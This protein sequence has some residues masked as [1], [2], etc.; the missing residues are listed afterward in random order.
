MEEHSTHQQSPVMVPRT[1]T[2]PSLREATTEDELVAPQDQRLSSLRYSLDDDTRHCSEEEDDE[3][4]DHLSSL[5]RPPLSA[6]QGSGSPIMDQPNIPTNVLS[7]VTSARAAIRALTARTSQT[8][9]HMSRDCFHHRA[10]Q[11]ALERGL[12]ALCFNRSRA[13][14]S[15]TTPGAI[16]HSR[17]AE[18]RTARQRALES[19]RSAA[20]GALSSG[21]TTPYV[22]TRLA[23]TT[24]PVR[25]VETRYGDAPT[26]AR[27]VVT[28]PRGR[29]HETPGQALGAPIQG[30]SFRA[31]TASFATPPPPTGVPPPPPLFTP[32]RYSPPRLA[33]A[34]A[35]AFRAGHHPS[36][37]PT[38][39]NAN[40]SSSTA[41]ASPPL[42]S[43]HSGSSRR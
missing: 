1:S 10:R 20:H 18:S 27:T 17:I 21:S 15:S 4:E 14:L 42:H 9:G 13:L 7:D 32:R 11:L 19:T 3:E 29:V 26:P 41:C 22:G 36:S 39:L 8:T 38:V 31:P 30:H 25:R 37:T 33:R 16:V 12:T 40:C 2:S 43:T 24:V 5:V 6:A 34:Y 28:V 35:Y 23:H